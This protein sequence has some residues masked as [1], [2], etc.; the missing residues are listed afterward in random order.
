MIIGLDIGTSSIKGVLM[1]KE[2]EVRKTVRGAFGYTKLENGGLEVTADNFTKVCCLVIRELAEAAEEP[3]QGVCASSASGNLLVLD[4]NNRPVTPI[5]NWQDQRVST[6]VEEILNGIDLDEFYRRV[7]W[8]FDQKTFPLALLCYIRKHSPEKLKDCGMVCMSTEYLY[9]KLTG[10]WGISTSAGTPFYLLDQRTGTYITELLDKLGIC[11]SQ[12]PPVMPCGNVL[13]GMTV[14]AAER[15]SLT[16]GTPVVLGSFDHPSAARGVG[17]SK[18]GEMLLSCGTSWVGFVPVADRNRAVDAKLLIDPFLAFKGGNW[19][20]MFSVPSLSERIRLYVN[21]YIDASENAYQILS[22]LAA[23]SIPGANGLCICPIEEPDDDKMTG[24]S[25]EDIARAIMEGTVRLLKE[26]L[27]GLA[28]QN[29]KAVSAVMVGGPSEDPMWAKL[30][31]EICGISVHVIH[32]AYAGAV[33]AA[34]LAGIGVGIY[35]DEAEA[36]AIC[37]RKVR[38]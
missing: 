38:D 13:G 37:N 15:T 25:K 7:G 27:D 23:K 36:H 9:Y 24:Y 2:G 14:E 18:E 20:A 10:K 26:K 4:K 22:E 32:G 16:A 11:E 17:V 30:I 28:E 5:F 21:Q 35:K 19:G 1:N 8:P 33:G 34:M 31:E 12:L 29:M 6:E 3:V